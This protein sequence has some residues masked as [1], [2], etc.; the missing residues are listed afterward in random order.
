MLQLIDYILYHAFNTIM[1]SLKKKIYSLFSF[2]LTLF[3]FTKKKNSNSRI[4]DKEGMLISIEPYIKSSL[5]R[6]FL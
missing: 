2:L 1:L 5:P 4:L 3:F 6:F